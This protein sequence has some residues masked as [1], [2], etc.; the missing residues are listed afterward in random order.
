LRPLLTSP[1][2][3]ERE[4]SYAAFTA[5]GYEEIASGGQEPGQRCQERAWA[6]HYLDERERILPT[7]PR[8]AAP[9]Y[10]HNKERIGLYPIRIS[11]DDWDLKF[12]DAPA[13]AAK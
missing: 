10:A 9:L 11:A 3:E 1:K 2:G 4:F 13:S 6:V 5:L 12:V 8:L 7:P